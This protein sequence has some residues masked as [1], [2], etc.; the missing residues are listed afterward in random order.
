MLLQNH[1]RKFC[2]RGGREVINN[3]ATKSYTDILPSGDD[4]D[5]VGKVP[6]GVSLQTLRNLL[7]SIVTAEESTNEGFVI[8]LSKKRRNLS[9]SHPSGFLNPLKN[10]RTPIT[11]VGS[12]LSLFII[13]KSEKN[14]F[15]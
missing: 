13:N 5:G 2:L 4:N 9:N 15:F 3:G 7:S 12:Y 14:V 10:P 8:V 6:A 11:G 1:T